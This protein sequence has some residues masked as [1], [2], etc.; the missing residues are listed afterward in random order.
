MITMRLYFDDLTEERQKKI[1]E[2]FGDN[3]NWDCIPIDTIQ[4]EDERDILIDSFL[5]DMES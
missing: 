1:I 5:G 3:C 4:I 2:V